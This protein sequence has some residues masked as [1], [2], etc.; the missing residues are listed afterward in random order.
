MCK[1]LH[2][3]RS[4]FY[5]YLDYQKHPTIKEVNDEEDFKLIK[6]AYDYRNRHKGA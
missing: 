1:E 6:Q 5:N 4:G 3:S 2:V